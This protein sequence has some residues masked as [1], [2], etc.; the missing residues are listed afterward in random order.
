MLNINPLL[1]VGGVIG[2]V[3]ALLIFAY[4]SVK[5]KK[6]AMGFERTMADGEILRRLFA[7]A[8]PYWAKFLLV[9]FLMLFSIAYDIISPLIVGA[10]EELVAADFAL[11]RLFASV[12]VYAGVLVFS[13]ANTYFQ[14]VIL[15]RVG[16]RIISDLREDLFTHIESL[17]HEQLNEIPVGKLVTR[18]TNDTNAISMMFTNLLVNLIKNAFVILGILKYLLCLKDATTDINTYL[19][20]N[21]SGIKVTQIFGRE[22]EKMAEFY[23]KSQT[24]SKV[25]QEQIFVFGVFRPLVYMLYISSI[26]C[27]FYLG[28]MGHLNNV[29]FLGQTITGGTID[30]CPTPGAEPVRLSGLKTEKDWLRIRG[31][32]IAMIMQDPMTSLN[33]LKTIGDQ[34]LEAV[35]LHQGLKGT[36]ARART[37][38]YLRDVGISDPEVRFKQYPHEFSGGMR[39]RVVIAIAV[40]CSPKILIC[41]EPTT[42]LDV[43][44]QAQIL[45]LLKELRAKY[46]LTIV[47][48]THDLGV[49]A[50]IADRVAV[51]YAG[52]IVEIGTADEIYYDP[53]HPY[54]WALLSSMP[55]MGIKGEDLFN[56]VGTPPNLFAEIRGDAFAPRNPQAL[57][58]D[59]VKRPP[60]FEVSP[61]H[62]AKT[63][64]LDP[65]APHIEPPAAVKKLQKEGL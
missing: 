38:E 33:P 58:I 31:R 15:Q 6:T 65:R 32:E 49:V 53:R 37:L 44:I 21:L 1:L 14:A 62:K 63:W 52:D 30:Y 59:Y 9:L 48:I 17:S 56:I 29:S 16:Q 27:L 12:A 60:Y 26:L 13:M 34:I 45:Q 36:E 61:T 11:S 2:A 25:T 19:S 57:K 8:K 18:V 23:Q 7:Y 54:T 4:A 35:T 41:D 47:M 10:I 64:L 51:M 22:D 5:D 24:L 39:Q 46:H 50:N 43:T 55:Q 3:T 40:A 20:E 42:A 28:G